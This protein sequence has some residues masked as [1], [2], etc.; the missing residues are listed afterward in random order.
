MS[1]TI[2]NIENKAAQSINSFPRPHV[3]FNTIDRTDKYYYDG[4]TYIRIIAPDIDQIRIKFTEGY[5]DAGIPDYAEFPEDLSGE[6]EITIKQD[7]LYPSINPTTVFIPVTGDIGELEE[8]PAQETHEIKGNASDD[9]KIIVLDTATSE[10][11]KA[12]N[13]SAGSYTVSVP[14]LEVD[15]LA[16]TITNDKQ[17]L[18]HTSVTPVEKVT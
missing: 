5:H 8:A 6:H 4:S 9:S 10:L 12:E 2:I 13:V 3:G 16:K 15:I 7:G 17:P 14:N 1:T 18:A 11:I